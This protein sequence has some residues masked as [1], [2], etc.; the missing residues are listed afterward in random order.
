MLAGAGFRILGRAGNEAGTRR[1]LQLLALSSS[2]TDHPTGAAAPLPFLKP[3]DEVDIRAGTYTR[4]GTT[5]ILV[6]DAGQVLLQLR[7]DIPTI[8]YPAH[9]SVPGGLMEPGETPDETIRRE[10]HEELGHR[11]GEIEKYGMILDAYRNLIHIFAAPLNTPAEQFVLG[12]GREIRF[13]GRD[14]LHALKITPHAMEILEHYLR[15]R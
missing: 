4:E 15:G 9:W 12:E 13:F 2:G 6:N 10:L 8:R 1:W 5:A 3:E 11:V 14:E 7:D